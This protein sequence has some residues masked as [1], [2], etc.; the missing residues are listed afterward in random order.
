MGTRLYPR[1]TNP[2][3]LEML[4]GVPAGTHARYAALRLQ[5]RQDDNTLAFAERMP[6]DDAFYAAILADGEL[7]TLNCFIHNGWGKFYMPEE[8]KDLD[9][10][11]AELTAEQASLLWDY[12]PHLPPLQ[13]TLSEGIYYC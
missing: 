12:N 4:A 11:C 13:Y 2:A 6:H 5:H 9:P 3:S 10:Y 8:F 1:T 7:E